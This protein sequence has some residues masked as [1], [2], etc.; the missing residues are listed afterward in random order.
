MSNNRKTI[1]IV[2]LLTLILIFTVLTGC[3]DVVRKKEC[4]VTVDTQ[5][6]VD[7][8]SVLPDWKD[9]E[10]HE[11]FETTDL[12]YDLQIKYPDLVYVFSIGKSVLGREIWCIRITNEDNNQEK[13][14][15]LIDGCIHG[16]EWEA[17][18]ACLYL[19]EYLLINFDYNESV[20]KILNSTEV[21]IVP[22]L[23]PDGRQVDDRFNNNGIDLNRNF[24]VD[25]GRIRGG[26]LRIG[27]I[28]GKR[29]FTYRT[30]PR[31]H[32]WFPSFPL[33]LLNSGRRAFSE[34]ESQAIRDLMYEINNNR[35][36]FYVNCHTAVHNFATPW[37]SFKPPF[38]IP[39]KEENIYVFAREWVAENTEYENA[40]MSF[41]GEEYYSSGTSMDWCYK[42][43]RIPS[44][45]FEILSQDYEPGASGGKHD[46]LTHWMK[47]TLP[48]FMYLLVNIENLHNWQTP[49]IEP[50]LPE[51]VPPEMIVN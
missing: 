21:Y 11:Y 9:G 26:A 19:A 23:N 10:Y 2:F 50:L 22:L 15:C 24:D 42:E 38:E 4:K 7:K 6:E 35:F 37:T 39:K 44:F 30:F 27:T 20:T 13:L 8:A 28:L 48:V 25:F 3:I 5:V 16:C 46:S 47:T 1:I 17:G 31:L 41:E 14:S 29:V 32:K 51:G 43:F 36:S 18:E 33:Y 45:T 12:L 34:P 49:D 40:R